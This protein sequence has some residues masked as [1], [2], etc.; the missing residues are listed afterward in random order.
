MLFRRIITVVILIPLVMA[1]ICYS[2][3]LIFKGLILLVTFLALYEFYSV[4][5]VDYSRL[6]RGF[7]I[8]LGVIFNFFILFSFF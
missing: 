8:V 3:P 4:T 2:D 1:A 7:G 6:E 5:L